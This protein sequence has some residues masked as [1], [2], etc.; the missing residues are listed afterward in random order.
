MPVITGVCPPR[1]PSIMFSITFLIRLSGNNFI[2]GS[3]CFLIVSLI[4]SMGNLAKI[5]SSAIF[6][7][8]LLLVVRVLAHLLYHFRA[9]FFQPSDLWVITSYIRGF[10]YGSFSFHLHPPN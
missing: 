3:L 4:S 5:L 7:G 6:M 9:E 10:Q 1:M 8:T 2:K